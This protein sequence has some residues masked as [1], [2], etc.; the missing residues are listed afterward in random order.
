MMLQPLRALRRLAAGLAALAM[1]AAGQA[2]ATW[3]QSIPSTGESAVVVSKPA[4]NGDVIIAGRFSGSLEYGGQ[5][6]TAEGLDDIFV[7]RLSPG[8]QVVWLARA[9]GPSQDTVETLA[10]DVAGNVFIVGS[11]RG[12]ARFGSSSRTAVVG[13]TDGYIAKLSPLGEWQWVRDIRGPGNIVVSGVVALAG[14]NTV[15]PPVPESVALV[16]T[17]SCS[18]SFDS[19][20]APPTTIVLNAAAPDPCRSG[21]TD[22][23]IAR[24]ETTGDW[25][26]AVN[27]TGTPT[28]L[29]RA[30]RVQLDRDGR[31]VVLGAG[32]GATLNSSPVTTFNGNLGG[33]P[34]GWSST[35]GSRGLVTQTAGSVPNLFAFFFPAFNYSFFTGTDALALR[36]GNVTV[37]SPTYN[38]TGAQ[39]VRVS[40]DVLRGLPGLG[41]TF[42]ELWRTQGVVTDSTDATGGMQLQ[43]LN[44][45]GAWRT[46]DTFAGSGPAGERFVRRD[47]A[48][49]AISDPLAA[50]AGFRLR[51]LMPSGRGAF[52]SWIDGIA[53]RDWWHIDDVS[54]AGTGAPQNFVL[55]VSDLLAAT[56]LVS[57]PT[58]LLQGVDVR[59]AVVDRQ[60]NR[61]VLAGRYNGAAGV[62]SCQTPAGSGAL[63]AS[64]SLDG[65]SPTCRWVRTAPNAAAEAIAVDS[66]GRVFATGSFSGQVKFFNLDPQPEPPD[67]MGVNVLT[68]T[69]GSRD[70]FV[71]GLD[72]DG[73][74]QWVTGGNRNQPPDSRPTF[75]GG[76]GDDAGLAISAGG[77]G[78]LYVGGRFQAI[79]RFGPQDQLV[80]LAGS[81]GFLANLGSDG[82]F[83]EEERWLAGQP[84]PAPPEAKRDNV[85]FVPEFAIDGQPFD[86]IGQRIFL[87]TQPGGSRLAEL[88]PLQ[89]F[90]RIEVR[91]RVNGQDLTSTQRVSRLGAVGWPTRSCEP[92]EAEGCY[93]DHVV[94]APVQVE[95]AEGTF[96]VLELVSPQVGSSGATY[97]A[98]QF[99]A[100]RTGFAALVYV[101]GPT[102]DPQLYA[103]EVEIVRTQPYFAVPL[104]TDNVPAEIGRPIIDSGH[105]EPGT[106]GFVVNEL[107]YYDGFGA[108]AAYNRAGR[109]GAIIPVNRYSSQRP[110]E[111]SRD[112]AVAWYKRKARGVYWPEK[113]VRYQPFWPFDPE[114]IIVASQQG[115]E[116]LGQAPLNPQLFPSAQIYIQND[117]NAPG[118]NPNDEHAFMAPSQ[119]G[120][121][122]EAVFALRSDFGAGI[123]GDGAAAS[124]PYVLVKYF[125]TAVT[126][127][128]FRV[129]RVLATGAGFEQFRFSGTAGTTVSPPYP[130]RLLPGCAQS[131]V[132]GQAVGE[133]PP[134]PFF[135]DYKNQLWA[136]SAGSGA[137]HYFYPAQPGFFVDTNNN[138]INDV[139]S[140]TC[141]PWLARLPVAQGGSDNAQAPI[142]VAYDIDWPETTPLLISGETLLTPKRGLPDILNQAAVEVVY[143]A[144]QA[145]ATNP[146]PSDTLAQLIDPLNPRSVVLPAVPSE[147]AKQFRTDGL[148]DILGS[149][150]GVIKLPVSL[151]KRLA[152]D[153][154][155]RRLILKGLADFTGAGDPFLLLNVM[156]Q[157]DRVVLK[158]LNGGNGSEQADF[159][160]S[161]ATVAANCSWDQAVEALF[162]LSRNPQR[163]QKVC[164]ESFINARRERV[165]VLDRPVG[166]TDVLV[167][168]QDLNNDGILEPFQALGVQ[169]ALSAGLSQGSGY[170]TVAFNNNPALNPL[171]VSLEVIQVGCLRSPAP[172]APP[173]LVKP[174]QGQINVISPENIFDEQLVLR[175]SGD[176]GGNADALEFEWF[177][178][179][180]TSGVPPTALPNPQTGQLNGWIQFPV[181]NPQGAVEISI[182]GANIQTLSD[183]WYLARYR[184]LPGCNNQSEWSLWAGQ[185]GATPL[186]QRAQLAEGWVK[187]VLGRLNPFEARVQN[188]AQAA[189]NNYAS[190]LVQLGQRYEGPIALNNDPGNLNRIGLIEAYTTV[191]RRALQLSVES[192]P[193]VNYA[194]ANA[195]VLLVASRLVDFY[196]LLGNEAYADAQ[197]PTIG[198]T[199]NSGNFSL[200]PSIFNFQNQLPSLLEEELI[201]LR[202]R[203]DSLGPVA[204]R[205]VYN[206][207]F[208]NFTTGQGEVAY[209][210]SYNITDQ[211]ADG[212]IDERDAR[213]LFPQGHGDAWGHYLTAT[214]TYYNLLRH[215]FFSWNPQAEA[216]LVAGVPIAVD[217]LDERQFALTAA[218]KAR[219]GAEVVNLTYRAAYTENPNGQWQGYADTRPTRAWG[220]SEWGRRAG[221]GAYFDWI[222]VNAILPE[223]E[224][225]SNKVGIQRIDRTTISEL[226]EILGHY[227]EI[228]RQVDKADSGLN[229]LGLAKNV[230]PFD[231]DPAQLTLFNRTQFEQVYERALRALQ[232]VVDVWDF[233]NQLNNQMR[234]NQNEVDDLRR[235]AAGQESDFANRLIEIFGYPYS[236]DIGPGGTYP[237]GYIG[238]DIYHYMY[239]DVPTLAG[240]PF[241]FDGGLEDTGIKR[242]R[243]FTGVYS[244]S[245]NGMNFF[246]LNP[247]PRDTPDTTGA[248]GQSCR[249]QPLSV[250]CPLG[251]LDLSTPLS[252]QY[253]TIESPDFG[254]WFTKPQGWTGQRRAPGRLQQTL[255]QMVQARVSLKQSLLDYDLLRQEIEVAADTLRATFD[256]EERNINLLIDQRRELRALTATTA[257]MNSAAKAARRA[258]E[259]LDFT[260][261]DTVECIPT[262][263]IAGL[264]AGGDMTSGI[265]C[266]IKQAGNIPK[267]ALDTVADG[268]EIIGTATEA[269]K[270]DVSQ[271]SG[272]R[273]AINS[274]NLTLFNSLGEVET[275]IRKEPLL[276]AEVFARTEAI[277]QLTGEYQA[278]LA[279]GLR[280]MDSMIAYRRN[281][282][283]DIQVFRY[284]DMAFRIFRN[285]AL[286]KYRAAF[287]LAARYVYL[288]AAAYDYD[289]NLLGSNQRAGQEFLTRI[290]RERSIGQVLNGNPVPGTPGLADTMAQL[291][292][293]F[294]VL[295]GQMGFNNPQVETNRFS[296][297]RELFR[298]PEGPSGDA[299]WRA[300]L[301]SFRVDDLWQV[302][303]FRRYARPFAPQSA[304]PQPGLV[305][306]F[307]TN[308][309]FG[310]NFF[311]W[312]LGAQDSSYDSSQFATRVR[313]VGAWFGNYASLPL[314]DDPRVYLFPVGADVMRSPSAN[315]FTIREWQVV[316]QAIPVPFPI[317]SQ[318][319]GR[320]DWN[321]VADTLSESSTEV[322]RYGRFRAFHFA[323]PF[324]DA[325][326]TS[327]SRLIGRSVWNRRWL[328]I[329]P[330]GTFLNDPVNGLDT[331]IQ[332]PLIPGGN[333]QRD[334]Q[335]VDDIRVF[336]KTYAYSGS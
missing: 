283:A 201:L 140:G 15:V 165:C 13:T 197:D 263:F 309:T 189:T 192:T 20:S 160:G 304:G 51:F 180:D 220:L 79:A 204:A 85:A 96:R 5:T 67:P 128:R 151:G 118:Y 251:D 331:F 125:D 29:D 176:F 25:K 208:W 137:V 250:G 66:Q 256:I 56:P 138:D 174:Y 329:I 149:A 306:E 163:I 65:I 305:I 146:L 53:Y 145:T 103:T 271:L 313:S 88:I 216:V 247:V 272:L 325:Q 92:G 280:V 127:W 270:E 213:I 144:I 47:G 166:P 91:W 334:G 288:A 248:N 17:Y 314:A 289:T 72:R 101:A 291:K 57:A 49:Y 11:F 285:D 98:G 124:D 317:G 1:L 93:Q 312:P 236:D 209:A 277:K 187:R 75:A 62:G 258:G 307:D 179:P 119:T 76:A 168:Y 266:G 297:R 320:F 80:S 252:V 281:G 264:A 95:P 18:A 302:P 183:N 162:R 41:G 278:S 154:Q 298:I 293:N 219:T 158:R 99:N 54:V 23:F 60:A 269:A 3:P 296:L 198:I 89:P 52:S 7:A 237:A 157:R 44:S 294:D 315:D 203:D 240:T 333:G 121:G 27:R 184:G 324:S 186:N 86:A 287:D 115:G 97:A 308:V 261:R 253:T 328:L 10:L 227:V 316:D 40:L 217:F 190:M 94:G 136:K 310:L 16:G 21:R 332:G 177:F 102:L 229:P 169:A 245:P 35:D 82:R 152:Y 295:K 319:L 207:L 77:T 301:E 303:E 279:E 199:T 50:H 195:A 107:A 131:F 161:C 123:A 26:W 262:V 117:F 70:P 188:F 222:T 84:I 73:G 147:V 130:V 273:A 242:I 234:R 218:A 194:P 171:P 114:R 68:A 14:D 59:D 243:E 235:D 78:A 290:V 61:L 108:D 90:G 64:Y 134:A 170:L 205:P 257:T 326:V 34:S 112:L 260:F 31:L 58:N 22:L 233:A 241:D 230:V 323:E 153:P 265:R 122:F 42:Y 254:F 221:M 120:S 46:V 336:F 159:T 30:S 311:G 322:R 9:G 32:V 200:A 255:Q 330:G 71:A 239:V 106:T 129:Y 45:A 282:A 105:D 43:Y 300:K 193:P 36:G 232:N 214:K 167:G 196:T 63:F 321:P 37:T 181:A 246:N 110:Q 19:G 172:P 2:G 69:G 286:Q 100:P 224:T 109:T 111:Q 148:E 126:Q 223:Q 24:V 141:V 133:Q 178:Q 274:S 202:G 142:R 215:P 191:M 28:G 104:F 275:L 268:L 81:D 155:N 210:L 150:D 335:G 206:R 173:T 135:Q 39:V 87:W 238:A 318:D 175:H 12:T 48:A 226:G 38:T 83:F 8:G 116:N 299:A 267:F 139:V 244:P 185:P 132:D 4:L 74:W 231:I 228:Q 55:L 225:D 164:Q 212:I 249:A 292:L 33:L 113:A 211:N 327:D 182:E 143:D 276:R 259:I 156:S 284:Q 6:I